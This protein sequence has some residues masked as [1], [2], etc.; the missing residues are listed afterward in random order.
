DLRGKELSDKPLLGNLQQLTMAWSSP[1]T[2]NQKKAGDLKV[3][4]LLSSSPQSWTTSAKRVLPNFKLHPE[5]GFAISDQ[6]GSHTL[7]VMLQGR[8]KSAFA[9][10]SSPLR[11]KAS[12]NKKPAGKKKTGTKGKSKQKQNATAAT[13][14]IKRA[15]A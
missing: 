4:P 2:I 6:R 14:F 5:H 15:P 11:V 12:S 3:T 8:F 1:I 9:G 7:A 10:Q 13:T